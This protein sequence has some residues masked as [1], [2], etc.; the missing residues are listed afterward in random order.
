MELVWISSSLGG[1]V[2]SEDPF[3]TM[4]G[5]SDVV[6]QLTTRAA[7]GVELV[8]PHRWFHFS[9]H[10]YGCVGAWTLPVCGPSCSVVVF[11]R[12]ARSTRGESFA[13]SGVSEISRE[14]LPAKK[15][16]GRR[17]MW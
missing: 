15:L 11:Q 16:F 8:G 2:A 3:L 5:V 1:L 7:D 12:A 14:L 4:R 13:S 17:C 9:A 6:F 10:G